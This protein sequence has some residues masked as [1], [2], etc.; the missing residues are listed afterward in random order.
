MSK[1][2]ITKWARITNILTIG[3]GIRAKMLRFFY[4]HEHDWAAEE[5]IARTNVVAYMY[6][7]NWKRQN[8]SLCRF[9][10]YYHKK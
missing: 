3:T 9:T 4:R 7:I 5:C 1:D 8:Y 6:Y 10:D 2:E